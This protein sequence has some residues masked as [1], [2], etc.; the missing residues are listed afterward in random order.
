MKMFEAVSNNIV[1]IKKICPAKII[2]VIS[3]YENYFYNPFCNVC[4]EAML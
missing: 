2:I 3:S 4:I 1:R